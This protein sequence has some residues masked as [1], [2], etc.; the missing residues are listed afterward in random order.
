M[1]GF[2]EAGIL[3]LMSEVGDMAPKF[4]L[5]DENGQPVSL[6]SLLKDGPILLAFYPGDFTPVCTKQLCGYQNHYAGFQKLG[7][8][9]VG[10]SKNSPEEHRR[11]K[12]R[13]GFGFPLLSD[14]DRRVAK[15]Y[16]VSS[17]LMLGGLSR[18]VFVVGV[19]GQVLYRYVEPTILSHRR[20]TQLMEI[21]IQLKQ[22]RAI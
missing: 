22:Q 17:L 3:V 2:Q 10:I 20:P 14:P 19:G 18:A 11:F 5:P 8:R 1:A 6:E 4:E 21:I 13:Y 15:A 16:R 7:I 12:E 9:I